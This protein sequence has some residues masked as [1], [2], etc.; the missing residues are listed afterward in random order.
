MKVSFRNLYNKYPRCNLLPNRL[1]I[2]HREVLYLNVHLSPGFLRFLLY[3]SLYRC[4]FLFQIL[5]PLLVLLFFQNPRCGLFWRLFCLKKVFLRSLYNRC[6]PCN[7]PGHT[8]LLLHFEVPCSDDFLLLGFL[9]FLLCY[10]LYKCK[11]WFLTLYMLRLS[12]PFLHP[13]CALFWQLFFQKKVLFRNLYSRCL[14]CNLPGHTL[15]L[16][17]FEV[18]CSGDFLLLG[19]LL[20]SLCYSLYKCRFWFLAP[21]ML[22]LSLF[23]LH[24]RYD[25]F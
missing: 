13:R 14:Q 25:L 16:L 2:S 23:F 1:Q 7:L 22:P 21:C 3:C 24:P 15:L 12:L 8:L 19:F 20:F 11:F 9:L 5:Y 18:L 17:H 6:L 10:S 4:R